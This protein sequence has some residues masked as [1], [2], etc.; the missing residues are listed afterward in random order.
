MLDGGARVL[1]LDVGEGV[2]AA[3]LADQ[4]RI[5]LGVVARAIGVAVHPHQA[6]VG[7]LAAAGAD[8]LADDLALGALADVDHLGAGV[9]LLAVMGQRHGVELTDRVVAQQHAGRVLPGDRRTGLDLG[10]GDLAARATA[11][12]TLGDEVVDAADAVL[13]ARV[14]VLHG[15]VLDLRVF[16]R[17]QLDHGGVQLVLVAHWRG[18]A[19]QV[20]HV[21]LVLAHDQGALELTGV[22]GVDAEVGAQLHRAAHA[23]GNEHEAAIGEHRRVER[24]EIVVTHRH[25]GAQVL[26]D[27]LRVLLDGL[28]HRAEDD[29]LLGQFLA[30][31][32]TDG[33]RV[34]HRVH[35]HA[36]Q[37][38][39]L[40][41]RHAQLVVGV[42]QFLRHVIQRGVLRALRRGVIAE[43]LQVD[44]GDLQLGPVRHRH[45]QEVAVGVQAPLR[46]P[47]RLFLLGRQGTDGVLVQARRQGVR[48]DLGDE[49]GRI[50]ATELLVDLAVGGVVVGDVFDGFGGHGGCLWIRRRRRQRWCG[51][52]RHRQGEEGA[53]SGRE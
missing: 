33:H 3:L 37:L 23:F 12:G 27:Q 24:G 8:A 9:G 31:G 10:P 25:H 20:G 34:E 46:H 50:L 39:A 7:V 1:H 43:R 45:G 5:A 21:G 35:R 44:R 17:D 53:G 32:G 2:R 52:V 22:A 4:Q 16:Q 18:A 11:F 29:A 26:A 41:Q 13:V 47:L 40:V 15:G 38:G 30:E 14:P 36:G 19:F 51:A 48:F 28:G 42:Q 6:A 49:A